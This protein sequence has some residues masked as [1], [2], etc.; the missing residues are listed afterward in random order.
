M[1]VRHPRA[2]KIPLNPPFSKG[3]VTPPFRK[4]RCRRP[5]PQYSRKRGSGTL[6]PDGGEGFKKAIF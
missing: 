5:E 4:G 2:M 3:E 1:T 6:A